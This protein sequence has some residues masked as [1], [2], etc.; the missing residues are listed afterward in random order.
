MDI[1]TLRSGKLTIDYPAEHVVRVT[2][3][4]PDNRNAIDPVLHDDLARIFPMIDREPDIRAAILTGRG[5]AFCGGGAVSK[6]KGPE[7]P[8]QVTFARQYADVLHL[9]NSLVNMRTPL[10]SAINGAAVGAGLS[11]ALLADI[12]IA[13]E[14]AKLFEGHLQNGLI[15]GDHA[16]LVWPLLCGMA[17]TKYHVM[18]GDPITG[19]EAADCNLIS[20]AVP[21]EELEA[22]SIAVASRLAATAPMA[23]RMTKHTLNHW[24]RQAMPTFELST[25]LELAMLRS[26]EVSE[27]IGAR[28]EKREAKFPDPSPF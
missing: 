6:T 20:L 15:A 11:L 1:S 2:L 7:E 17:K 18:L 24:Y 4:D 26:P 22:R 23:L 27:A 8:A 25:A 28:I 21:L 16:V 9:I 19:R 13:A 12:S 10:V 14:D 3:D 5:K